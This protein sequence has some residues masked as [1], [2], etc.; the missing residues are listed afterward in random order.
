[1]HDSEHCSLDT[2]CRKV[3]LILSIIFSLV[4][5]YLIEINLD[6]P[7]T[8]ILQHIISNIY[9]VISNF[10]YLSISALL[11]NEERYLN[12][13][14]RKIIRTVSTNYVT[15]INNLQNSEKILISFL[16]VNFRKVIPF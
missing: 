12:F 3:I 1:M 10:G 4:L 9:S 2:V 5:F 14:Q 7:I 15:S 8:D 6:V 13:L 11:K 16:T